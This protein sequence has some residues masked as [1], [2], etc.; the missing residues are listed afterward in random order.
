M[1]IFERLKSELLLFPSRSLQFRN[2]ESSLYIASRGWKQTNNL[3]IPFLYSTDFM[4]FPTIRST[5]RTVLSPTV[6]EVSQITPALFN[7]MMGKH[8]D[9][10]ELRE[11]ISIRPIPQHMK[12]LKKSH[13]LEYSFG[14]AIL[15]FLFCLSDSEDKRPKIEENI[16]WIFIMLLVLL[17]LSKTF[18]T[19]G[20]D[21]I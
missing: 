16:H 12:L 11:S 2:K 4:C 1:K 21:N 3:S 6:R 5:A 19:Q 9:E 13:Q 8:F 17:T 14:D 7:S 15:F 20:C 10:C 18:P